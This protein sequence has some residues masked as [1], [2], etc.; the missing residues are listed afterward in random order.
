L[1]QLEAAPEV[2]RRPR[3]L[4]SLVGLTVSRLSRLFRKETGH[5][6]AA[7]LRSARLDRA[8]QLLLLS[9]L[10]IKEIAYAAGFRSQSHFV[11]A[12]KRA[13]GTTPRQYRLTVGR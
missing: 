4:A 5:A 6:L 8:A 13:F 12:F 9:T 2:P 11:Q 1:E 10:S 7:H 3:E